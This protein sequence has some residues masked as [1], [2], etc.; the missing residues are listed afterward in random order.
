MDLR[1]QIFADLRTAMN[2]GTIYAAVMALRYACL[3]GMELYATDIALQ[4]TMPLG[5]IRAMVKA[6]KYA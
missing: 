5:I 3:G 6:I 4:G 2:L 1:V